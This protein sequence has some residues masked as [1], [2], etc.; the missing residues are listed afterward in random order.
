MDIEKIKQL[1]METIEQKLDEKERTLVSAAMD[2]FYT[3][4]EEKLASLSTALTEAAASNEKSVAELAEAKTALAAKEEEL[5]QLE[6]GLT[7]KEKALEEATA[8]LDTAKAALENAEPAVAELTTKVEELTTSLEA[9]SVEKSALQEVIDDI[10]KEKAL[11]ERVAVLESAKLLLDG[12]ALE[13]Q[14]VRVAALDEDAFTAY[15]TELTAIRAAAV[16]STENAGKADGTEGNA[17]NAS[18]VNPELDLGGDT[19]P[20]SER[21]KVF[22]KLASEK[23][24]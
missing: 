3:D 22:S 1:F 15:V 18:I 5:A 13:V 21:A 14:K 6:Q 17:E 16:A 19:K 12:D 9:L 24:E 8:A 23:S 4:T 7:D 2:K 20:F 11:A 10:A